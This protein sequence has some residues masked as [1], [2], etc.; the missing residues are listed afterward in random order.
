MNKS[1][2]SLSFQKKSKRGFTLIEL[3]I[4]IGIIGILAVAFLPSLLNAPSKARDT[5]RVA[6]I[7]DVQTFLLNYSLGSSFSVA[8]AECLDPGSA[9]GVS[10]IINDNLSSFSGV[11]PVDPQATNVNDGCNGQYKALFLGVNTLGKDYYTVIAARLENADN[12]NI[13]CD[14]LEDN[15]LDDL[16]LGQVEESAAND[17]KGY[18]YAAGVAK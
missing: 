1:N 11:F 17:L 2:S 8:A 16:P 15:P 10:G 12:A 4:V 9:A 3:L 14:D 5:Q 7:N 13:L 6:A 18:C